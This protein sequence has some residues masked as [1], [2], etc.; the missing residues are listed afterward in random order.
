MEKL[1]IHIGH[2]KTGSSFLQSF[3]AL[4][5]KNFKNEGIIYNRPKDISM[6]QKGFITSGNGHRFIDSS[7]KLLF[8]KSLLKQNSFLFSDETF[9]HRLI[10]NEEFK[11]LISDLGQNLKVIV[12]TRN[13][14]EHEFS[15]WGQL[16]KRHNCLRDLN[17][18]LINNGPS[19]TYKQLINWIDASKK[20][21]FNLVVRNY[22]NHKRN[23]IEIFAN[24]I[25]NK[26]FKDLKNIKLP[27]NNKVN[28]SM[29]FTEYEVLRIINSISKDNKLAD[30]FTNKLP[31]KSPSKLFCSDIAYRKTKSNNLQNID[32]INENIQIEE[33]IKIEEK[34]EVVKSEKNKQQEFL[35]PPEIKIIS[36]YLKINN[37]KKDFKHDLILTK[38]EINRLKKIALKIEQG[39]EVELINAL[40]IM[41]IVNRYNYDEGNIFFKNKLDKLKKR[42]K[43]NKKI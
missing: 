43:N 14:F 8:K 35:S 24:D 27:P 10:K 31:N 5:I 33:N 20:Y 34:S 18:Y 36:E 1:I 42:I 30:I 15:V 32:Y 6:A 9:L 3:L 12:F 25:L 7:G 16:V 22:S 38:N 23:L 11:N 26:E 39:E 21:N 29:N 40:F 4:N 19:G 37:Y 2:G 28:R 17:S 41:N 13:L